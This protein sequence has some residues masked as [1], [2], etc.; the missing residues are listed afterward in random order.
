M[1]SADRAMLR[2]KRPDESLSVRHNPA[3]AAPRAITLTS[4][5]FADGG[6]IPDR[7]CSMDLGSN[8]SRFPPVRPGPRPPAAAS[9]IA[10]VLPAATGHVLADGFLE[11][12]K[13]G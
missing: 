3:L 1:S 4:T 6:A 8:L 10:D 5:A 12:I 2:N 13:K 9:G 7:H 11:G